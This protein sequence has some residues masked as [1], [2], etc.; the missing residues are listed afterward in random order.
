MANSLI[1]ASK[2]LDKAD[3]EFN[4]GQEIAKQVGLG[5]DAFEKKQ[6]SDKAEAYDVLEN[7]NKDLVGF[8][9]MNEQ[10]QEFYEKSLGDIS[11]QLAEAKRTKNAKE[12][13][14]LETLA[15]NLIKDQNLIGELLKSHAE[16]TLSENYSEG[17]NTHLLDMLATGKYRIKEID[18]ERRVVFGKSANSETSVF[19]DQEASYLGGKNG[20]PLSK[21]ADYAIVN[22]P[23]VTTPYTDVLKDIQ[24]DA[25]NGLDF[26]NSPNKNRLDAVLNKMI[27]T[28]TGAR[29]IREIDDGDG[30]MVKRLRGNEGGPEDDQLVN[31]LYTRDFNLANGK[32]LAEMWVDD[33]FDKIAT[34][35]MTKEKML[36]NLKPGDPS[37]LF[38]MVVTGDKGDFKAW[39]KKKLTTGASNY[40][41]YNFKKQGGGKDGKGNFAGYLPGMRDY[42]QDWQVRQYVSDLENGNKIVFKDNNGD[43]VQAIPTGDGNYKYKEQIISKD[44]LGSKM[45]LPGYSYSGASNDGGGGGSSDVY[46]YD[47]DFG[48]DFITMNE[49]KA[50]EYLEK[51]LP[52]GF[53]YDQYGMGDG[54]KIYF[55]NDMVKINLQPNTAGGQRTNIKKVQDFIKEHIGG[56]TTSKN[57]NVDMGDGNSNE[58]S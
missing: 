19:S 38:N 14:R 30:N 45:G 28:A 20:I 23:N 56:V 4:P 58:G 40:H 33:H 18:G 31:L 37:G 46:D 8:D 43:Q 25:K 17:A 2:N 47:K 26:E 11:P 44:E 50:E 6:A 27:P 55:G 21:L 32:N 34:G 57:E 10:A 36:K 1:A 22:D 29:G 39:V 52:E 42:Q 49:E 15:S 51:M 13:R 12:V 7:L 9:Y 3:F 53:T 24:K 48:F 54:I 41:A 35:S 16:D 5:F